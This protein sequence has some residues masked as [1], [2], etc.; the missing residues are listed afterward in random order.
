[1]MLFGVAWSLGAL[2]LAA[3]L[4]LVIAEMLVPGFF[5][6]FLGAG[7]VG[8]GLLVL[9]V[10]GVPIVLQALVFAGL[11]AGAVAIGWR[12]YRGL[13]TTRADPALNDRAAR[14]IGR[15]VLVC[16]AIVD[17]E[18]RVTV[19]DG[20]WTAIGPDAAVGA[21]VRIVGADGSVLRVELG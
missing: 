14:L 16:E 6:V 19:G 1:M 8:T 12:W 15:R 20:A 18:G 13:D 3:A 10:P 11:T 7:A 9:I 2:W 21:S 5:L 4:A 17:G